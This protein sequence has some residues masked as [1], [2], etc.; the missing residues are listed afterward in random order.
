M[1]SS[2]AF[3]IAGV[4]AAIG[5]TTAMDATRLST[6][7]ALPLFP[8]AALLWYLQRLP[9][10]E[11]GLTLGTPSGYALALLHPIAVLGVLTAAAFATGMVD[12]T[13]TQWKDI[14]VR[15]AIGSL[16]GTLMVLL[17]EEGFFRGW[18]W[19]SLRC[20][21]LTPKATLVA[22]SIA[23]TLWHL[24]AVLLDTGFDPPLA[25]VPVFLVT[26]TLLGVIWGLLRALSG[27]IVVPSLCHAAWNAAAYSLYGFGTKTGALG[28]KD[29]TW[30]GPEVGVYGLV[31]NIVF[32]AALFAIFS[33]SPAR[34]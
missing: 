25:Q 28:I 26:A 16:A 15:I 7:S 21:E 1:K 10:R 29:T 23:F 32:A 14:A 19:A 3:P 12:T 30:F 8:L 34:R 18:L 24:S 22:S 6:F 33:R 20:A 13:H 31:L 11:M 4:L 27:S 2:L 17:T 5:I 9:R